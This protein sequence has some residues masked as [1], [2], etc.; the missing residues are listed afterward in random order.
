MQFGLVEVLSNPV[1]S[2]DALGVVL[3]RLRIAEQGHQ[4]VA[5][6]FQDM[7]PRPITAFEASSR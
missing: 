4:P 5:E 7:S 1:F 6:P 2:R 3:L